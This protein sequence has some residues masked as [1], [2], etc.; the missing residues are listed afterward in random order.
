MKKWLCALV[1]LT[2]GLWASVGAQNSSRVLLEETHQVKK[3][4][5]TCSAVHG[6]IEEFSAAD[7]LF[8]E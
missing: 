5:G 4:S 3:R 7:Y 6:E 1:I 2:G 8:R